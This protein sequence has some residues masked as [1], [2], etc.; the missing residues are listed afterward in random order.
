LGTRGGTALTSYAEARTRRAPGVAPGYELFDVLPPFLD[1]GG[2]DREGLT[3]G[4][5]L[6]LA[7]AQVIWLGGGADLDPLAGDLLAVRSFARYRHGCGCVAVSALA[8][9]RQGRG[10]FDAVLSLDLMP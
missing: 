9:A 8:S 6:T 10:G 3:T 1:V 5:D 7:V 4:A 2:Y